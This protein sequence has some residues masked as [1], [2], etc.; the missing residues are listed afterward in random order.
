MGMFDYIS[1]RYKLPIKVP[2]IEKAKW[3]TKDTPAMFLDHYIIMENGQLCHVDYK[4]KTVKT[5][6]WPN[7][8]FKQVKRKLKQCD[9]TGSINFYDNLP[10]GWWEFCAMF[11]K[12]KLIKIIPIE[13]GNSET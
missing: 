2:D 12:G 3:Q 8:Y 4:L 9:F 6:G 10:T 1:L 11:E 7:F 13:Q 5:N